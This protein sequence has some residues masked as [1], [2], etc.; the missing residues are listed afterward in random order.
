MR[1]G[2]RLF[3]S[4]SIGRA[5][6]CPGAVPRREIWGGGV[7]SMLRIDFTGKA[8]LFFKV[9][10]LLPALMYEISDFSL[11]FPTFV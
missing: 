7:I 1:R 3:P 9:P 10:F 4:L 11:F 2:A 5:K 6:H 8:K